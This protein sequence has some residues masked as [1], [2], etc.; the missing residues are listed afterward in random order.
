MTIFSISP[1]FNM[2]KKRL[3]SISF[4]LFPDP[5][6]WMPIMAKR[7]IPMIQYELNLGFAGPPGL[8]P[9][10]FPGRFPRLPPGKFPGLFFLSAIVFF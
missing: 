6:N 4:R 8:F 1:S 10:L 3:E 2:L 5:R 7:I 9:G